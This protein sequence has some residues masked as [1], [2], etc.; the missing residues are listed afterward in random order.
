MA[1]RGRTGHHHYRT[2]DLSFA[3]LYRRREELHGQP[4]S[5]ERSKAL[6]R[7]TKQL[8]NLKCRSERNI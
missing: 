2:A 4:A 6:R 3:D 7:V 1:T 8:E 5:P